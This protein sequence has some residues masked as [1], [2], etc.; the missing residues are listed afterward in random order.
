ML[1]CSALNLKMLNQCTLVRFMCI[2]NPESFERQQNFLVNNP[3]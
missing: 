1:L 2:F 3:G